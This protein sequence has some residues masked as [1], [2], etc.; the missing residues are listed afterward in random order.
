MAE[1]T[2]GGSPYIGG[3]GCGCEGA[4]EITGGGMMI[5]KKRWDNGS[6]AIKGLLILKAVAIIGI[7]ILSA[8]IF[9]GLGHS[10]ETRTAYIIM[11]MVLFVSYLF[12]SIGESDYLK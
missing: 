2:V 3:E 5:D 6:V 4:G 7:L 1:Y 10:E 12:E 8:I 11:L 9:F